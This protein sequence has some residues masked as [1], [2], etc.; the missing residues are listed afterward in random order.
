MSLRILT[1]D[2]MER[3][4]DLPDESVHVV[5][6]SPPYFALRSYL[7]A[8]HP[9]KPKEIGSETTPA[10]FVDT[11]V[12]VFREVRRVLH[13]TGTIWV[14]LGDSYAGS[15]KGPTGHNGIGDQGR[16]Q[17]FTDPRADVWGGVK[18]KS[19]MMVP[20]RVAIALEDDGWYLRSEIVWAK[21]SAMP[22][23]VS[24]RP[25]CAHEKIFLLSKNRTYFY[26]IE[27]VRLPPNEVSM[28]TQRLTN[29][30]DEYQAAARGG[31]TTGLDALARRMREGNFSG[32]NLRNVWHLGPEP[33]REQHYASYPTEIPRRAISAG[34][35]ERGACP[36]CLA[37][38]QRSLSHPCEACEAPIPRQAKSCPACGHVRAWKTGRTARPEM[39][40]T[41]WSTPGRG[42]PRLPGG[43]KNTNT[44][45]EWQPTCAH[46]AEPVPC[47]VL[48]PFL[49]SGTTLL[50]ADQLGRDGIGIELNP[51]Y[52]TI[53]QRRIVGDAPMLVDLNVA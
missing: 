23:S 17:G 41:D 4:A 19:L 29:R 21:K 38:W 33:Q 7:P 39:L 30:Y 40:S 31:G 10:Q 18:P 51:A 45:T 14:N 49:G 50:V 37:P 20:S 12:R 1:G 9:D 15:G 46:D 5:C 13:P 28:A 11:M 16:R 34:S 26:D 8:D 24:D 36:E 53:A 27:A 3:L 43:F 52:V 47:T 22:E 6:T 25:T 44:G 42:T 2:V 35:S 48:D 32:A